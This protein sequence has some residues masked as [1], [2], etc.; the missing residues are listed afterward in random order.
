[1]IGGRTYRN[2]L[3][4]NDQKPTGQGEPKAPLEIE[5]TIEA[6]TLP[7]ASDRIKEIVAIINGDVPAHKKAG[8]PKKI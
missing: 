7:E 5:M 8:K 3:T 4:T 6:G 1:M 2:A